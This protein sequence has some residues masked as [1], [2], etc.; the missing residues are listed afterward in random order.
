MSKIENASR[1]E[2][3]HAKTPETHVQH[4][5]NH[6]TASTHS[7]THG[8]TSTHSESHGATSTH[9]ENHGTASTHSE[10][11]GATSSSVSTQLEG[12]QF[13]I[14]NGVVTAVAEVEHGIT[15]AEPIRATESYTVSGSE[16]IKT[17]SHGLFQEISRYSDSNGDGIYTEVAHGSSPIVDLVGV[18]A[19]ITAIDS[20][21]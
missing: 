4:T 13:T 6:G 10:N 17:E 18:T 8:T 15:K 9:S 12:Y 16:V 21:F 7:E 11:H 2:T 1:K 14:A 19:S 5:E 20:P 3:S